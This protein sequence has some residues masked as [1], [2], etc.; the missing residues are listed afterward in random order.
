M[1]I[2]RLI[3]QESISEIEDYGLIGNGRSC[4]LISKAGSIDWLCW[5]RF[6]SPSIFGAI[7]DPKRG[8]SWKIQP[9]RKGKT[10]RQY[11]PDTN[12]LETRFLVGK[13]EVILT[14]FMP[15][16]SEDEKNKQLH[17]EH[18][19]VRRLECLSGEV[20]MEILFD[21]CPNYGKD[22]AL[23]KDCGFLG[24]RLEVGQQLISLHSPIKFHVTADQGARAHF[25]LKAGE[26]VNFS[27]CYSRE[28]PACIPPLDEESITYKLSSTIDW[29]QKWAKRA[30]YNG[31]YRNQVIRSAL[32]LKLLGYAPSGSFIAAPTTSLPERLGG[33]LNWDYRYCWL[34]DASLTVRAL[35][36][37]GYH[38]ETEAFISWLLHSTRLTLPK[39]TPAYDVYGEM[40][41]KETELSHLKGY[42]NSRPVRISNV[43]RKQ[44]QLDVYGEVLDGVAHFVQN[45]GKLDRESQKMACKIGKYVC[46][47]WNQKDSGI[48]EERDDL[49]Y[50]TYSHLMCWV[51]LDKL[52]K[53]KKECGLSKKEI[54]EFKKN[55]GLIR[56]AIEKYAWNASLG[57]YAS[58][59]HGTSLD[60]TIILMPSFK[61]HKAQSSRMQQ[62]YKKIKETLA[63]SPGLVYRH[64]KSI[65]QEGA[66]LVCSF[67]VVDFLAR[68]GGSLE[69]AHKEFQKILKFSNDLGLFPEEI[70]VSTKNFLGNFPQAFTHLGLINA[71]LLLQKRKKK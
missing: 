64:E 50:Y 71:A 1:R 41:K 14:D 26:K 28:G 57:A 29:W 30:K 40:L 56:K 11:I 23:I 59:L 61:F 18:E 7:L 63:A 53:I 6:D 32:T 27:L 31:P 47:N 65:N 55:G 24:L 67:W 62:T 19:I 2:K 66:F 44:L 35:L 58:Y 21:P 22:K 46:K 16:L 5:P 54:S 8:G 36:G 68:G 12:V 39:L 13:G 33:E 60:A 43:V 52:L 45:G 17:P 4:A 37:L 70:D 51:A 20:E 10:A 49:E 42:E 3:K 38:E 25:T 15:A 34:R 48:W 69:K 9:K